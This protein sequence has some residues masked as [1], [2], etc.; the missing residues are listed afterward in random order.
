M[1]Q[2]DKIAKFIEKN[3]N[4]DKSEPKKLNL[5]A[6]KMDKDEIL[7]EKQL[8][9]VKKMVVDGMSPIDSYMAVYKVTSKATASASC[10][11]LLSKPA[12]KSEVASLSN[13]LKALSQV[14][15]HYITNK[16]K[17]LLSICEADLS[18]AG[19]RKYYMACLDMINKMGGNYESVTTHTQINLSGGVDFGGWSPD[20]SEPIDNQFIE[21]SQTSEAKP[22]ESETSDTE[23]ENDWSPE[24]DE[25]PGETMPF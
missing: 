16:V 4:P 20:S 7:N 21:M 23:Q 12:I 14:P 9:F 1:K 8:A 22:H 15:K 6:K 2:S 3:L 11:R 18:D 19:N 17:A 24:S 5:P 10:Y 25:E 13:Q